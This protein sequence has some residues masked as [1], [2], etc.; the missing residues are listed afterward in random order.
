VCIAVSQVALQYKGKA[1]TGKQVVQA[2]E[3]LLQVLGPL[4]GLNAKLADYVFFPLSHVFRESPNLPAKA[5]EISLQCLH[6]LISKGWG[7]HMEM[8]LCKQLL[9]LL[10]FLVGGSPEGETKARSE[11]ISV[12]GLKCL[13]IL[14]LQSGKSLASFC[15][16]LDM[17]TFP[18]IGHVVT[19]ILDILKDST[20]GEVELAAVEALEAFISSLSD[21]QAL[22]PFLPGIVSNLTKLLQPQQS[23]RRPYRV[24]VGGLNALTQ[25]LQRTLRDRT[26]AT[27]QPIK[28]VVEPGKSVGD[29]EDGWVKATSAQVHLAMANVVKLR[30]HGKS[31][32]LLALF[33]LC[34]KLVD[35]CKEK[36]S[37]SMPLLLET[38]VVICSNPALDSNARELQQVLN[39]ISISSPLLDILKASAHKWVA[40]LPRIMQSNDALKH[41]THL[42]Q[43]CTSYHIIST[44]DPGL[45][46]LDDSLASGLLESVALVLD[47][48]QS[49]RIQTLHGDTPELSV[50]VGEIQHS[51]PIITFGP[52]P[53]L[54]KG[55][56]DQL[57]VLQDMVVSFKSIPGMS[58]FR[59]ALTANLDAAGK[60][61]LAT[62]WLLSRFQY[63]PAVSHLPEDQFLDFPV[64]KG[65]GD[66][67]SAILFSHCV[68]ILSSPAIEDEGDW[69][70]QAIALEILALQSCKD[71]SRFR[72]DLVDVLFPIVERMGSSNS[73][74]RRYAMTCL[75]VVA[76]S[77]G[78]ASSAQLVVENAD[79]LVNSIALKFNTFEISPQ[80]PH[81][82]FMMIELCGPSL[83]PYVDDMLESIF[84]A[85]ASFHGYPRL[86]ES[87]FTVLSSIVGQHASANSMAIQDK[88]ERHKKKAR[89]VVSIADVLDF[90][91]KR[92]DISRLYDEQELGGQEATPLAAHDPTEDAEDDEERNEETA[93]EEKK[94]SG[95][96]KTY[97]M[98]QSIVRLGQHYLT[99]ASPV[100]RQKLL[101]L[102][103]TACSVLSEDEEQFLPLI[104]DIWPMTV[105]RLYDPEPFV[106]I[107]ATETLAQMFRAAGDFLSSR[108]V[109]EW[110]EIC[111]LY[112]STHAKMLAGNRGKG[113]RGAFAS[114]HQ[115]WEALVEMLTRLME[116][117]AVNADIEDDLM[118][119]LGPYIGKR[120]D[121]RA[122][123]SILN[124]DAVWMELER[125]RQK[126]PNY[127]AP[128]T[129]VL[130]GY[131]FAKLEL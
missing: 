76:R 17:D 71:E 91:E 53:V 105:R 129:P 79:Y 89:S 27:F 123:L 122:A 86:V 10:A 60:D 23:H 110:A 82:L 4:S 49:S 131:T 63:G 9:I 124:D 90:I 51:K 34:T 72:L 48:G 50:A 94:A 119:M 100:L 75:N 14:F 7:N 120:S 83:I 103:A 93:V 88:N 68:N 121:L 55:R 115:V 73:I 37:G 15:D 39:L 18:V 99:H 118:E 69:R 65:D 22:K 125:Q 97:K 26:T 109:S 16:P 116:Y 84:S 87:L 21:D 70:I 113:G 102:T 13:Y 29:S 30:H 47:M 31:Q 81:V 117:V 54:G 52:L 28:N 98:A 92:T 128:R 33:H 78:Y 2:L 96:T 61:E 59:K 74:L 66:E 95:P 35:E 12:N 64:D 41:R 20:S 85:L 24:L 101:Q 5:T 56:G 104:N 107:A 19:V 114:S 130:E 3:S 8:A 67:D 57:Q 43:I 46:M 25:L 44:L 11:E 6:L 45:K 58:E 111:A 112:K 1:A 108:I 62:L 32:V 42:A 38:I 106:C 126:D 77:C 36:L 80:A 127:Q 40:A